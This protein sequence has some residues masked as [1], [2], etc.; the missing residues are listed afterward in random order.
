[1]RLLFQ[2]SCKGTNTCYFDLSYFWAN[3][4]S[5]SLWRKA[6]YL[7]KLV[8]AHCWQ[9]LSSVGTSEP[10]GNGPFGAFFRE[11][12]NLWRGRILWSKDKLRYIGYLVKEWTSFWSSFTKYKYLGFR[13]SSKDRERTCRS[14]NQWKS[15]VIFSHYRERNIKW[16]WW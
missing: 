2:Y 12:K 15:K 1:M 9:K 13:L 16:Y 10:S 14:R 7:S 5:K 6:K 4:L 3:F 11:T 8:P